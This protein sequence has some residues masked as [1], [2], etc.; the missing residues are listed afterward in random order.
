M[1]SSGQSS[2]PSALQ[3]PP[4]GQA[5]PPS[6][7]ATP[8]VTSE[9]SGAPSSVKAKMLVLVSSKGGFAKQ[10]NPN[11]KVRRE[12][13]WLTDHER[14]DGSILESSRVAY[15][16]KNWTYVFQTKD[17]I[18]SF[19]YFP[20]LNFQN[21]AGGF[22]PLRVNNRNVILVPFNKPEA[23]FDLLIG[24]CYSYDYKNSGPSYGV[25][26][27]SKLFREMTKSEDFGSPDGV[28]R[29]LS[30]THRGCSRKA[31]AAIATTSAAPRSP[32]ALYFQLKMSIANFRNFNASSQGLGVM[33]GFDYLCSAGPVK[34]PS[35]LFE[36]MVVLGLHPNT[37]IRRV[38][39]YMVGPKDPDLF[40]PSSDFATN[41]DAMFFNSLLP[42]GVST[43]SNTDEPLRQ[44]ISARDPF[45]WKP[46]LYYARG[47]VRM[48]QARRFLHD[49]TDSTAFGGEFDVME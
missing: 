20:T 27:I 43:M 49:S 12:D 47:F 42:I 41:N 15:P 11:V 4:S 24:D 16:G 46:C 35:R 22:G 32:S 21:A 25:G 2:G 34:E 14:R 6:G 17:Q 10:K 7:E 19:F 13:D 8:L 9:S 36:S 44:K 33:I 3:P 38:Q 40:F 5:T 37:D 31:V 18:G 45:G 28:L 26:S 48:G 39:T 29:I 30:R 1:A 23:E